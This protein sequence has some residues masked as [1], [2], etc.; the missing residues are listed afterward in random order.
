MKK[1]LFL[2]LVFI[3]LQGGA[4]ISAAQTDTGLKAIADRYDEKQMYFEYEMHSFD[5]QGKRLSGLKTINATAV[6]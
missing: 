3:S 2:G 6:N 5:Q 1:M 4:K